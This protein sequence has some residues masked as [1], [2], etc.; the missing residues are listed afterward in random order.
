FRAG[1]WQEEELTAFVA[2]SDGYYTLN[3][4]TA[5]GWVSALYRDL[6]GRTSTTWPTQGEIDFWIAKI[7]TLGRYGVALAFVHTEEYEKNYVKAA[8]AKLLKRQ[9]DPT[10]EVKPYVDDMQ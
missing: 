1:R 8:Y 5:Q 3:G 7:P 10:L 6:L 4:G 2:A 9:A